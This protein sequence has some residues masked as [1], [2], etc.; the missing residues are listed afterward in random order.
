MKL[1][2]WFPANIKPVRPGVYKTRFYDGLRE[3]VDGY[4]YWTGA[5]WAAQWND[6]KTANRLRTAHKA[7]QD[8]E[9]RGLAGPTDGK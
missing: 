8:K 1:T 5:D 6:V 3:C 4:T 9:W 2:D 7:I